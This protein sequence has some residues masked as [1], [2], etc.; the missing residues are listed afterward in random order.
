MPRTLLALFAALS[1]GLASAQTSI[2][3]WYAFSD[4]PRS[5]W[6]EDRI[7]EFNATLADRGLDYQVVGER[8]GS[9]RETLQAAVLAARQGQPPH[10]VQLFEVGSQLAVD[11]GIFEPIGNV[12][13][14]DASVYIEPVINYY[15]ID[16]AVNSLPFNSSSPILYAN[17]Q[18]MEQAGLDPD[19]LPE[20]FG[21][22]MAACEAIRASSV[23]AACITFP[24][25]SW[26]FEQWVAEQGALLVNNG[27]GRDARATEVLLDSEAALRVGQFMADLAVNRDYAYTGTLEDWGGS[28]AIFGNQEA[29]FFITSTADAGNITRAAA[30]VG[31]DVR[32]GLLPI[33]DGVER[34]GVVIGGASVW[35]TKGNPQ[36][37]L[38]I[39]RD[40]VLYMTNPEN[41]VSWHKLTGYYPVVDASVELLEQEGWFDAEPNF[42]VAFEQLLETI[43]NQATAGA[44]LGSFLETRTIIGEALQRIYS[45]GADVEET[46]QQ[47]KAEADARLA[48]YNANF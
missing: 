34:N 12:G 46:M 26:L 30:D 37:E 11:S 31:F 44:L 9:Y 18:L 3:F 24:L 38:E 4:A 27:N 8:K 13:G 15:T 41:M 35:L 36:E 20:T 22:V 6:I 29:V 28:E 25:H 47:A 42:A 2:E 40:F 14:L 19:A 21:E 48:E 7:A 1:I 43:P 23:T 17:V 33:P 45:S 32:T 16:G 5:G 39:A 10:L